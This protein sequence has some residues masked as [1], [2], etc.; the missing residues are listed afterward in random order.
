MKN[1]IVGIISRLNNDGETEYLLVSSKRDFGEYTGFYYPPGGHQENDE[2]EEMTLQRECMEEL[3]LKVIPT[4][5]V[6]VT[7]GDISGQTTHWWL[8]ETKDISFQINRDE[9]S[10][11]RWFTRE[12][13]ATSQFIWPATKLFFQ[14]NSLIE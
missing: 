5:K 11:A 7:P 1:I 2:S 8:C 9:L 14:G 10:E 6:D 3:G 4:R 12:A 13:V